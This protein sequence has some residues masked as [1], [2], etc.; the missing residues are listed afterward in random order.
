[1]KWYRKVIRIRA[2]DSPCVRAGL[3]LERRG[4]TPSQIDEHPM[5]LAA[6]AKWPGVLTYREYKQRRATWDKVRQCIG[7]DGEFY[8]GGELLMYPPDWLNAAE[9]VWASLRGQPR[10]ARAIGCDPGEGG[11]DSAWAVVDEL[12]VIELLAHKTPN[13]TDIPKITKALIRQHGVDPRNVGIDRGGGGYQHACAL[14]DDG[15]PVRTIAFG[16]S[17]LLEPIRRKRWHSER[18]ENFEERYVYVNRRA[19]MAHELRLLLD[20]ATGPG[21]GLPVWYNGDRSLR[22]Q[23]APIPLSYDKEGRIWLPPKNKK[24]PNAKE[25]T[26]VEIIGYSPDEWDAVMVASHCLLHKGAAKAVAGG[27]R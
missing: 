23:M 21:W 12:G 20:P 8:E 24:D 3:A 27:V 2:E 10:K 9:N 7:L 25:R 18:I 17:M 22:Q 16:E 4:L 15:F 1:M 14:E 6:E 11:A 5:V 13:T 19:Q 26:L